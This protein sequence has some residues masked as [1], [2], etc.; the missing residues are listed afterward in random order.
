MC[1]CIF[2]SI[3]LSVCLSVCLSDCPCNCLR[4][5]PYVSLFVCMSVY[6]YF[7]SLYLSVRL[8]VCISVYMYFVS[9]YLSVRLCVCLSVY[10]SIYW[11][12][13]LDRVKAGFKF[14]SIS[15]LSIYLSIHQSIYLS[16]YLS[17]YPSS[18][19]LS[20][21]ICQSKLYISI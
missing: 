1:P 7:V 2:L 18:I 16:I 8:F 20:V 21:P 12:P 19:Y 13:G 14:K 5:F 9:F 15:S 3:C 10:L 17:I 6:M 11:S 4:V